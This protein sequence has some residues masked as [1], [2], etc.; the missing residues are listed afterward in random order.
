MENGKSSTLLIQ[1]ESK[2]VRVNSE[3]EWSMMNNEWLDLKVY[4]TDLEGLKRNPP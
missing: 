2:D 4:A 1:E 3:C